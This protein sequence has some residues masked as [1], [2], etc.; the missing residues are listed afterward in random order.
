MVTE[1]FPS[2]ACIEIYW[3][4]WRSFAGTCV[5]KSS[6]YSGTLYTLGWCWRVKSVY[7]LNLLCICMRRP[8]RRWSGRRWLVSN[9]REQCWLDDCKRYY[10]GEQGEIW[11]VLFHWKRTYVRHK[12]W[13]I[14]KSARNTNEGQ[15]LKSLNCF[16]NLMA[17]PI[18]F[19]FACGEGFG[20]NSSHLEIIRCHPIATKDV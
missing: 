10:S 14:G 1:N 13:S 16:V 6:N 11:D 7:G 2:T 9:Y 20:K 4:I 5:K 15:D 19:I 12:T 18:I 8:R 17:V 3:F